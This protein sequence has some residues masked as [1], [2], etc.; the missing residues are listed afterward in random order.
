MPCNR[1]PVV[2]RVFADITINLGEGGPAEWASGELG[3]N[4]SDPDGD[5]LS[6]AVGS[7]NEGF[8]GA[9]IREPRPI[10]TVRAQGVGD[11]TITITARD[12]D[13]LTDTASFGV[14]V[15]EEPDQSAQTSLNSVKAEV[16]TP[17]SDPVVVSPTAS[18]GSLAAGTAFTFSAR[19]RNT[20]DDIMRNDG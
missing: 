9:E 5:P 19:V 4:L 2:A 14:V 8:A 13:G 17:G 3:S 1:A 15:S 11:A 10:V 18:V 20:G 7:S 12:P 6:Y 16:R